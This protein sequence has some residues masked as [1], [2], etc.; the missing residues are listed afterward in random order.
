MAGQSARPWRWMAL[1]AVLLAIQI[2]PWWY[3]TPD[4]A[5]YLSIAR[6][7]AVTHR[8]SNLGGVHLAYP[9][10]YPLLISP[11]FLIS[12]RPFMA[13]SIIHWLIALIF[14]VGVYRWTC[15]MAP[16]P[17]LLLT[18]LSIVNVAFWI[19]YRR[20]LSELAFMTFMIWTVLALDWALEASS[21]GSRATRTAMG[22]VLLAAL[23]LI[24]EPGILF[25]PGFAVAAFLRVRAGKLRGSDGLV[26]TAE[27]AAPAAA[28]VVGFLIYD[29]AT[30]RVS[31]S[32]IF[33]T[34]LGGFL[35]PST[36]IIPRVIEGLRL[37][38]SEVGRLVVPGMFKTYAAHG[39]WLHVNV[40]IYLMVFAVVAAG[41]WRLVRCRRD[42]FAA[43]M[44]LYFALYMVWAFDADTRYLLPL[45]PAIMVSLWFA[46]VSMT[47]FPLTVMAALLV[48]HL[49]V[50]VGYW[51]AVEVPRGR[52]C[53]SQWAS[54]E[55][56]APGLWDASGMVVAT[57]QVPECA[58]LML[59]FLIDRPVP[60]RISQGDFPDARW[61]LESAEGP[62]PAGFRI[63]HSQGHY[64]LLVRTDAR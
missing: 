57:H 23:V 50:A 24:R 37:R 60:E 26:M 42:V 5:A 14:M 62:D 49:A 45:L 21:R 47:R 33:G 43:T 9:P 17:A 32:R 25:A 10:G 31:P 59:T 7:I 20:T 40:F 19:Y 2:S 28:A 51:T 13:V 12:S 39:Q 8:L 34:H 6:A 27:V 18:G 22:M 36:P 58:R 11:A 64:K 52:Q 4:A 3:P 29:R 16:V 61:I 63:K 46:I 41:L 38:I 55:A 1:L 35:E 53:N 56:L 44:P 54:I 15:R 48:L 30:A